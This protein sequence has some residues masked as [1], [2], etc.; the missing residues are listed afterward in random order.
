MRE[1]YLHN[2]TICLSGPII[3]HIFDEKSLQSW[4]LTINVLLIYLLTINIMYSATWNKGNVVSVL[5]DGTAWFLD[6]LPTPRN[7]L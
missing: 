2:P 6:S 3:I 7:Q 1:I 4:N 5:E